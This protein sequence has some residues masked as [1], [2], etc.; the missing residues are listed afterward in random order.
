MLVAWAVSRNVEMGVQP[1]FGVVCPS[2]TQQGLN[3]L[4]KTEA[5]Q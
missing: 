4:Y 1:L 5:Q 2:L 3:Y